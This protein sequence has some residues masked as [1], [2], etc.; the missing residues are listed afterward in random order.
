LENDNVKKE[1]T[2]VKEMEVVATEGP[3]RKYSRNYRNTRS[4]AKGHIG[5]D[6]DAPKVRESYTSAAAF[7]TALLTPFSVFEAPLLT[8][9]S[10]SETPWFTPVSVSET[11]SPA[12]SLV[13]RLMV[14]STG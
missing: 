3:A 9:V 1:G 10:V 8:P 6:A 11:A 12:K 2:E 13:W 4:L 7:A 5:W 14:D